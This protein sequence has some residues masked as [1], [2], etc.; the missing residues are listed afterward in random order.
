MKSSNIG[1]HK[2]EGTFRNLTIRERLQQ[3]SLSKQSGELNHPLLGRITITNGR[4]E[5]LLAM[6]SEEKLISLSSN[7]FMPKG[8][9][10]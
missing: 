7:L 6:Y 2:T 5:E 4:A 3:I 8:E 9:K 1:F 10:K